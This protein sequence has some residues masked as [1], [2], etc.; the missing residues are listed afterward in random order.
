MHGHR[1]VCAGRITKRSESHLGISFAPI[2]MVVGAFFQ[3]RGPLLKYHIV[4]LAAMV[5]CRIASGYLAEACSHVKEKH[6]SI[7]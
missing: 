2:D 7:I 6:S 5:L 1:L 3:E 4:G